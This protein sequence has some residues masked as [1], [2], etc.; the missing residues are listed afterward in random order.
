MKKYTFPARPDLRVI[1]L[2]IERIASDVN[3]FS[4]FALAMAENSR[5]EG[6][7]PEAN[8]DNLY[9]AQYTTFIYKR[10]GGNFPG[11]WNSGNTCKEQRIEALKA[12]RRAC[13]KAG[14]K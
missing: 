6:I 9:V 3:H 10:N 13:V 12:F 1:D 4:C 8:R 7:A 5:C 14:K 2:A 11:W